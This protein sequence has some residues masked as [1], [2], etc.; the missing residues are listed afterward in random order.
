MIATRE[1]VIAEAR[2]YIGVRFKL[3]G[4]DIRGMDCVGLLYRVGVDLGFKLEDDKHYNA[5]PQVEK[6]NRVLNAY[7]HKA[8]TTTPRHGQV[9]KLRQ[10][11]FP[12][13][14][15]FVSVV[16]SRVTLIN[17][18]MKK[19]GVSEDNWAEWEPLVMEYREVIGV[20]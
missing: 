17:A 11:R 16:G 19:G 9:V 4:R 2:K 8:P 14:L 1:Q 12:M 20:G 7:T 18:N 6:I 13:H 15:G 3:H 10:H 5:E